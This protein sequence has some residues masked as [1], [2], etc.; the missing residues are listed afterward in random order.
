VSR[1]TG[2]WPQASVR[3][4]EQKAAAAAAAAEMERQR[5]EA[6]RQRLIAEEK[7]RCG[8]LSREY[9]EVLVAAAVQA[10]FDWERRH[11]W[12]HLDPNC[13]EAERRQA[14]SRVFPS[15]NRSILTEIYLCHACSDH[16]FED[17]NART[18]RDAAPDRGGRTGE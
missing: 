1:A 9:S 6:E 4:E 11:D 13:E 14:V 10:A 8:R 12:D 17:G 15:W 2:F 3:L 5:L 16:D 7:A 18:G